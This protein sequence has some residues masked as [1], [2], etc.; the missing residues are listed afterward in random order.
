MQETQPTNSDLLAALRPSQDDPSEGSQSPAHLHPSAPRHLFPGIIPVGRS[1]PLIDRR[2]GGSASSVGL[3]RDFALKRRSGR[4]LNLR[5]IQMDARRRLVQPAWI[6]QGLCCDPADAPYRV[7]T[8]SDASLY[9]RPR[10]EGRARCGRPQLQSIPQCRRRCALIRGVNVSSP[11]P[12]NA[13]PT[14]ASINT[15]A[16]QSVRASERASGEGSN[17]VENRCQW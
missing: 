7:V 17:R 9:R 13:P 2:G 14:F 4:P 12:P 5:L 10:S 11:A 6:L 15:A 3:R 8:K 16:N 1:Q